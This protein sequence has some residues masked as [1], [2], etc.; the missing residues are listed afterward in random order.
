MGGGTAS[1]EQSRCTQ[2]KSPGADRGYIFRSAGLPTHETQCLRIDHS[3]T[4]AKTAGNADQIEVWAGSESLRRH[5][6]QAAVAGHGGFGLGHN[7]H[8]GLRQA[9]EHLQGPSEVELGQIWK[10][11]EANIKKRHL[12]LRWI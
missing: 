10:D 12:L 6:T 9:G 1:L 8:G 7:V 3:L 2:H 5:E 4:N 11:H